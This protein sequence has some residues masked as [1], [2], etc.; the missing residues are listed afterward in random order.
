MEPN[1]ETKA[2][3]DPLPASDN[4]PD[5]QEPAENDSSNSKR[6]FSAF[7]G[8]LRS[9]LLQSRIRRQ[10]ELS[11]SV[12]TTSRPLRSL[13]TE[14]VGAPRTPNSMKVGRR[15]RLLLSCA[16]AN[17]PSWMGAQE[18]GRTVASN[19]LLGYD[20]PDKDIEDERTQEKAN[21]A[22]RNGKDRQRKLEV[23]RWKWERSLRG[24]TV[25]QNTERSAPAQFHDANFG[26]PGNPHQRDL[27]TVTNRPVTSDNC[28]DASDH[29]IFEFFP[30]PDKPTTNST[31]GITPPPCRNQRNELNR[32]KY[33]S[34]VKVAL[35]FD[36]MSDDP[37]SSVDDSPEKATVSQT[38]EGTVTATSDATSSSS[39]SV[40][41]ASST[42][43]QIRDEDFH[44][45]P[46]HD[47]DFPSTKSDEKVTSSKKKNLKCL[48]PYNNSGSYWTNTKRRKRGIP[49]TD[50]ANDPISGRK[51][52]RTNACRNSVKNTIA[53]KVK[54]AVPKVT[55]EAAGDKSEEASECPTSAQSVNDTELPGS[56]HNSSKAPVN[57][58]KISK[59]NF[60]PS[61]KSSSV[62]SSV[63]LCGQRPRRAAA[64]ESARLRYAA[65]DATLGT[66]PVGINLRVGEFTGAFH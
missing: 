47:V 27:A 61:K 35:S 12:F 23:A 55:E 5:K 33:V 22:V 17:A 59:R 40:E 21:N 4:T 41:T 15:G 8:S 62:D 56:S 49:K 11:E 16:R 24:E 31:A 39:L 45:Y 26:S 51:T 64:S 37:P 43:T 34:P 65:R 6:F 13:D 20:R 25:A 63:P 52:R 66:A 30:S 1:S 46:E 48:E 14:K 57:E 7:S 10:K 54:S 53:K 3:K 19:N 29:D 2:P 32:K 9:R 44:E 28:A 38:T 60:L 36:Q 58:H 42:K 18:N 50:D